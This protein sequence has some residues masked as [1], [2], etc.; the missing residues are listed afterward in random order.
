MGLGRSAARRAIGLPI[1]LVVSL[2]LP[3]LEHN[4]GPHPASVV[5][6][7]AEHCT[8]SGTTFHLH[9]AQTRTAPDCPACAAGPPASGVLAG[10]PTPAVSGDVDGLVPSPGRLASWWCGCRHPARAPPPSLLV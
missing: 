5:S 3:P 4:H 7:V 1:T 10:A 6:Q 8:A 9:P 2:L